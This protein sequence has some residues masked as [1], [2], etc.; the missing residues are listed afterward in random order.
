MKKIQR[1]RATRM[2]R[3]RRSRKYIRAPKK[4]FKASERSLESQAPNKP[5]KKRHVGANQLRKKQ[6]KKAK[7]NN[8]K[9]NDQA[10]LQVYLS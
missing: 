4:S 3:K 10:I 6:E 8:E 5:K 1:S 7:R 9:T 2:F